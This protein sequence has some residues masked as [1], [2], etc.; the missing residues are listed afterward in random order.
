MS[1]A[2]ICIDASALVG[3]ALPQDAFHEESRRFLRSVF[4][5][6]ISRCAPALVLAECAGP[7]ARRTGDASLGKRHAAFVEDFFG[8]SLVDAS[9]ALSRRAAE[10]AAQQYLRGPDACYVAAAEECEAT[11]VTWD[12]EM[13]NRGAAV[14]ETQTPEQWIEARSAD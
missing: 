6:D 10:I 5:R 11:L 3:Y 8:D 9:L 14:V 12:Q 7:I 13:L 2:E 4:Q 1:R